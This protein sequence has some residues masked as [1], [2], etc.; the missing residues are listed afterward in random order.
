MLNNDGYRETVKRPREA[1]I[2]P[3]PEQRNRPPRTA[4]LLVQDKEKRGEI[5]DLDEMRNE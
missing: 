4:T 1:E 2:G 3:A 5:D